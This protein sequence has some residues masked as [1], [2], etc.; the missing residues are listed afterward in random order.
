[1]SKAEKKAAAE[2]T[3]A[4][5][6]LFFEL[7]Y[8]AT[9][10]RQAVFDA[11]K[12]VLKGKD[13]EVTPISFSR[14]GL[15]ARPAQAVQALIQAS[16]RNLTTGDQ[17][18]AQIEQALGTW[19]A[20]RAQL[21]D[22]LPPLIKAAQAANI[23]VVAVSA[24]PRAVAEGL[25]KKLGL[26]ALGVDLEAFDTEDPV[27]PRADHWLRML[28]NREQETLPRIA[29]VSS[30]AACKGALTA[31]ATC[32]AIPDAYTAFE[33]FSGAKLILETLGDLKAEE[34]LELVSRR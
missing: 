6:V 29:I 7:E 24:W 5:E 28:K 12:Q 3:A 1:M 25:M 34:I 18:T 21:N 17:L 23:Q 10:G 22:A 9:Q 2:K 16:G 30:R 20:E 33:D 32:I 14:Y 27:F 26:D 19:F 4:R 15:A 11:M 31:G 8:I 13:L